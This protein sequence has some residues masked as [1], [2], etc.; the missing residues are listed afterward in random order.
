MKL[1]RI[2]S[3]FFAFVFIFSVLAFPERISYAA[4][5]MTLPYDM[6]ELA[7]VGSQKSKGGLYQQACPTF[8]LAYAHAMI[9]GEI[10]DPKY[11]WSSS[12]N[13]ICQWSKANYTRKTYGQYTKLQI[14]Q[15]AYDELKARRLPVLYVTSS[16]G[17]EH[18]VLAV[19]Y[20]NVTSRDSLVESNFIIIDPWSL[21]VKT[22]GASSYPLRDRT[23]IAISNDKSA[24]VPYTA[25]SFVTSTPTY[26][27]VKMAYAVNLRQSPYATGNAVYKC[28][29]GDTF[30]VG[31]Y[32]LNKYGNVWYQILD[33]V[34]KDCYMYSGDTELVNYIDDISISSG[35]PVPSNLAQG[36]G[37][38]P[39]EVI[40]SRHKITNVTG[41]IYSGNTAIYSATISPNV[42][43]SYSVANT[44]IS[45]GLY[46]SRL[47][48]G[49]YRYVLKATVATSL[50]FQQKDAPA[51]TQISCLPSKTFTE[52]YSR[53]FT[54]THTH[55]YGSWQS[56]NSNHWKECSCGAQG[57]EGAHTWNS[58]VVTTPPTEASAGIRT[59]A[60]TVCART[61]TESIPATGY[62]LTVLSADNT[63]GS[64][65]GGGTY[66]AGA[67]AT[68]KATPNAGYEFVAWNDGSPS[69]TR[70]ITVSSNATYTA[71]FKKASSIVDAAQFTAA[72]VTAQPGGY[73]DVTVSVAKNP[74]ISGFNMAVMFDNTYLTVESVF[75]NTNLI[76]SVTYNI[77]QTA[78]ANRD[79][80]KVV[81]YSGDGDFFE[82]GTIF[83][84]RFKVDEIAEAGTSEVRLALGADSVCNANLESIPFSIKHGS[85][86]ISSFHYGDIYE[87][88]SIDIR[89]LV[90]LAQ[91]VAGKPLTPANSQ[92]MA[93]D[94]Y[95]DGTI[96]IRDLVKLAQY[97]A[98][99]DVKLGTK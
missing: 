89:D 54:V 51:G 42:Y 97:I 53:S 36:T 60:C 4:E 65:S 13:V 49:T 81:G 77:N 95:N 37:Y 86:S 18:W 46:F 14:M 93:M 71:R 50:D 58:G 92:K 34:Y 68:I 22:L 19:G 64:V 87:D 90:Y 16:S 41:T 99:R 30:N 67:S 45:N 76:P 12:T 1:R 98:G 8:C 83:T 63:M 78:A 2:S 28:S 56:D 5:S 84:I 82:N 88:G 48:P 80:V 47:A 38:T 66:T 11:Y 20:K 21:S 59:Y 72:T 91:Y 26:A 33:G 27:T 55:S 85:V 40:K 70:T 32:G 17:G 6:N 69:A 52:E 23:S 29:V 43:G 62:T 79:I 94:V 7:K 96:D 74:G 3:I 35:N 24:T 15:M 9:T 75:A 31:A 44:A 25:S 73:A 10:R 61:R 39:V 57:Y